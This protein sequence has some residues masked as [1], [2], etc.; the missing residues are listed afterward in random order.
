M[1]MVW[2][3]KLVP[4]LVVSRQTVLTVR[5]PEGDLLRLHLAGAD[6]PRVQDWIAAAPTRATVPAPRS[7][8][9]PVGEGE[10]VKSCT[11]AR[12]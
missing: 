3:V 11:Q 9:E 4:L 2:A 1:V 12:L 10:A 6:A 5:A 7:A 8:C